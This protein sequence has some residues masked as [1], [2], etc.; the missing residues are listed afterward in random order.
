MRVYTIYIS[1]PL[2]E[3]HDAF[4]AK[5]ALTENDLLT[6]IGHGRLKIISTQAEERLKIPFLAE[7]AERSPSAIIG[8]RTTAAML[9]ADIVQTAD[10][11]R[12]R[13]SAHY[14]AIGELSKLLS[15]K[16]GLPADKILEFILWPV[17][18]RRAAVCPLLDRGSKGIPPIGMGPFFATFIEKIGKKDLEFESLMVSERV[19]LG[20]ALNATVFPSRDEPKG[21]HRLANAMGDALNFFR[22]FNIRIA[23]AWV[24]NVERK[25]NGRR[26]LPPLP[27]LEFDPVIPIEEILAATDRPVMRNRGRALFSRLADMTEEQR[28]AEIQGLNAALRRYGKPGGIIS[29]DT[30]D[31]G[32]SVASVAADFVYPPLAGLRSL[33]SQLINLGRKNPSVDRLFEAIQVDLF[34][35]SG[36]K[37]ELDFLSSI[38]RVALLKTT[39]VS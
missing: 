24:G 38:N 33:G 19:H 31:T 20:H 14:S 30:I 23:A 9:I 10:E 8:R 35:T 11:Y 12:L 28:A 21:L 1:P 17:Q 36:K 22:S 7:A 5:Q 4:L 32:I 6:L 34:P 26:L 37:R 29:L 15:D 27:L 25:E 39:K 13:D 3:D 2:R 16:S 18:A